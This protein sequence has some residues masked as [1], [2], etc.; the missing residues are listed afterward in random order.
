M[1]E[2]E[3][4]YICEDEFNYNL[5]ENCRT[6]DIKRIMYD[7]ILDLAAANNIVLKEGSKSNTY[8]DNAMEDDEDI[9]GYLQ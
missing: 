7:E 4:E 8:D 6:E 3:E 2:E 1:H 5:T 9:D